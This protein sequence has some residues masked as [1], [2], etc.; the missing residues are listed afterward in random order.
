MNIKFAKFN[1]IMPRVSSRLLPETSAQIAENVDL[2]AGNIELLKTSEHAFTLPDSNQKTIY[3]YEPPLPNPKTW[4]SWAYDV[5]V[6]KHPSAD[7]TYKRIYWTGDPSGK[8][9]MLYGVEDTHVTS[10]DIP[11][12]ES[13]TVT[14]TELFEPDTVQCVCYGNGYVNKILNPDSYFKSNGNITYTWKFPAHIES[15]TTGSILQKLIRIPNAG[16]ITWGSFPLPL[17]EFTADGYTKL[18]LHMNNNATDS[19]ASERIPSITG[20]ISYSNTIYKLGTYSAYIGLGNFIEYSASSDFLIDGDFTIEAYIYL[21][22]YTT[23]DIAPIVSWGRDNYAD[24]SFI[25]FGVGNSGN[26]SLLNIFSIKNGVSTTLS[27]S[28]P[29]ALNQ[30]YHVAVSRSGNNVGIFIN[31]VLDGTA[32]MPSKLGSSNLGF[33]I[34]NLGYDK[35]SAWGDKPFYGY[36]DEV[37]FTNGTCRYAPDTSGINTVRLNSD[38]VTVALFSSSGVSGSIAYNNYTAYGRANVKCE[39]DLI[40]EMEN[41]GFTITILRNNVIESYVIRPPYLEAGHGL[42][43]Y[44]N[45][46]VIALNSTIP[47]GGFGGVC[48]HYDDKFYLTYSGSGIISFS[49]PPDGYSLYSGAYMHLNTAVFTLA[50]TYTVWNETI[51]SATVTATYNFPAKELRYAMA[52]LNSGGDRG[53]ASFSTQYIERTETSRVVLTLPVSSDALV[54]DKRLYRR[55]MDDDEFAFYKMLDVSNATTTYVDWML[56][57]ALDRT[58]WVGQVDKRDAEI[59]YPTSSITIATSDLYS[60]TTSNTSLQWSG[61]GLTTRTFTPDKIEKGEDSYSATFEFSG[62]VDLLPSTTETIP[63]PTLM[64]TI[65]GIGSVTKSNIGTFYPQTSDSVKWAD[66]QYMGTVGNPDYTYQTVYQSLESGNITG[67]VASFAAISDAQ[68]KINVLRMSGA[69]DTVNIGSINFTGVTTYDQIASAIQT[70]LESAL[71]TGSGQAWS[72][73]YSATTTRFTFALTTTGT[74]VY[75]GVGFLQDGASGTSIAG[76]DYLNSKQG[77]ASLTGDSLLAVIW[78]AVTFSTTWLMNYEFSEEQVYYLL[79]YVDDL[80][81]ESPI[82]PLSVLVSKT[83]ET[84]VVLTLPVSSSPTIIKKRI[85]RSVTGAGTAG[86]QFVVELDNATTTYVDW[87]KT[88]ALAENLIVRE[89]A[90]DNLVGICTMPNGF[91]AAFKGREIWFSDEFV[92]YS[93]KEQN[94]LSVPYDIIAIQPSGN[95]LVV[96]TKGLP[97]LVSGDSPVNMRQAEIAF[98]QSCVSKR[99]VASL[100]NMVL[101]PS[102]DGLV[103]IN[104]G[105]AN[106]VTEKLFRRIDW[107]ALIPASSLAEVFDNRYHFHCPTGSYIFDFDEIENGMQI[108]TNTA[109]T[110]QAM[111]TDDEDDTMYYVI[112]DEILSW[113]TSSEVM[114]GRWKSKVFM[115]DRPQ[116]FTS[117]QVSA[118]S[119][120][121]IAI[122]I[123]AGSTII[124]DRNVYDNLSF[125]IPAG[126]PE[127]EW[128]LQITTEDTIDDIQLS[129]SMIT[130]Q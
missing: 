88:S 62:G 36:I 80:K 7:D 110:A 107:Q 47:G 4:I 111:Y 42:Q 69:W 34:G 12:G 41:A 104:G 106:L 118:R 25:A 58:E 16:D 48:K 26:D 54:T 23:G 127:R 119:Y 71:P 86:F 13:P 121:N 3:Y 61:S 77:Y 113:A 33:R 59:P 22:A 125:R 97:Y 91:A 56:D 20:T 18:L 87:I 67:L 1:G 73:S 92:L 72:V 100:R 96:M 35:S 57:S 9:K 99:A 65:P 84:R 103:A 98:P 50:N 101:Y 129:S 126:R 128:Q 74:R 44:F 94:V 21:T 24:E 60:P 6:V 64:A 90:P 31:G 29:I 130:M 11:D 83:P 93:W 123:W 81:E 51:L 124:V 32:I 15:G 102:P 37:R 78:N 76:T 108:T 2:L 17:S 63:T 82:S 70:A 114:T 115:F 122:K 66:L 45:G 27:A 120:N 8:L 43:S 14:I 5:D 79:T 75:A 105:Q 52:Y 109:G 68:F 89:N 28:T 55:Y 38:G 40:P 19:S 112:G 46:I 117:C 85:Y 49:D 53:A 30:W 10:S 95:D 39:D 116:A